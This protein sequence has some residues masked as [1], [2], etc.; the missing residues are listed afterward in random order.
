MRTT[1]R[2]LF[3]WAA[4]A[5]IV[6]CALPTMAITRVFDRDPAQY[7]T[8]QLFRWWGALVTRLNPAW[9]LTVSGTVPEDMRRPFVVV[10]NHQSLGDIPVVCRL[11]GEMKWIVKKELFGAPVF[12]WLMRMAGDISVN[13]RDAGSRASVL[14]RAK[15]YLQKRCSVMFFPEGT[16]SRD[17]RVLR[18]AKGPFRL[19]VEAGV[20]VLPLAIDGTRGTLPKGGW[21]F[22]TDCNIRLKV[23]DPISPQGRDVEALHAAVRSVIVEQVAAWR[24]VAPHRVDAQTSA[25]A[26]ASEPR[27]DEDESAPTDGKESVNTAPSS[28]RPPTE[29]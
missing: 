27:D 11:P 23:L 1:L 29:S 24:G 8:G 12:G 20:D 16:R 26:G 25:P 9:H 2:S 14:P 5:G 15:D 10:A 18:F 21:R 17:G 28:A 3:T 4:I 19:A 7:R 6:L 13:R 22:D